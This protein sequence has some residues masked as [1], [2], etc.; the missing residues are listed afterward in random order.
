M[1][2]PEEMNKI[3]AFRGSATLNRDDLR[4]ALLIAKI[5]S[6]HHTWEV[7]KPHVYNAPPRRVVEIILNIQKHSEIGRELANVGK[8]K[9]QFLS[10]ER[11]MG[12]HVDFSVLGRN[13]HL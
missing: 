3:K 5:A 11:Q 7:T 8:R 2:T 12:W 10:A 1:K 9:S 13:R 6:Q 4:A